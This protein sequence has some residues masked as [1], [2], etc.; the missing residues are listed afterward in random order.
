MTMR[1]IL[2]FLFLPHSPRPSDQSDVEVLLWDKAEHPIF[3]F[4]FLFYDLFV[5]MCSIDVS[6]TEIIG[7]FWNMFGFVS[8]ELLSVSALGLTYHCSP[9]LW[10][11]V[12]GRVFNTPPEL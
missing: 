7:I 5:F 6:K 8:S 12:A 4:F 11:I 2:F 10:P 9:R 3:I 1:Q